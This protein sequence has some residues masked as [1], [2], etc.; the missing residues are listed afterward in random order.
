VPTPPELDDV[1]NIQGTWIV[2]EI[3]QRDRVP[4]P[5]EQD[6]LK[7]G[8]FKIKFTADKIVFLTDK[9]EMGYR[10]DLMPSPRVVEIMKEDKVVCK[11]I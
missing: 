10:M 1:K 11:G 5:K 4:S 6:Y 9:S 2:V 7:N 3:Q 8:G